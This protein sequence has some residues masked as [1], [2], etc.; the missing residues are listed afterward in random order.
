M[1]VVVG[2]T[3]IAFYFYKNDAGECHIQRENNIAAFLM[4]GSY[5]FLFAQFFIGRYFK[6][7]AKATLKK[8]V[9]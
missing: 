1:V 5:L 6:V 9:A 4:Y 7:N 2:D 3:L 8:K